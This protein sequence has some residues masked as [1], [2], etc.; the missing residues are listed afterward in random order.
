MYN[1]PEYRPVVG[2]FGG[3]A[4]GLSQGFNIANALAQ[5][6]RQDLL[7]RL[8][9]QQQEREA[10]KQ[11]ILMQILKQKAPLE[12][13]QLLAQISGSQAE[14]ALK[15]AQA[16]ALGAK[17]TGRVVIG[18]NG[19]PYVIPTDTSVSQGGGGQPNGTALASQQ[20]QIPPYSANPVSPENTSLSK[21]PSN[22]PPS[23]PGSQGSYIASPI[24]KSARGQASTWVNPFTHE[25]ISAV[26]PEGRTQLQKQRQAYKLLDEEIIP[27][28]IKYGSQGFAGPPLSP[29][30]NPIMHP[31]SF[32]GATIDQ[33]TN[34]GA[35][36]NYSALLN[37]GKEI[38]G[39]ARGTPKSNEGLMVNEGILA[40][41]PNETAKGYIARLMN[42]QKSE[43]QKHIKLIDDTL[44]VGG[45]KIP[46]PDKEEAQAPAATPS[47]FQV[48]KNKEEQIAWFQNQPPSIKQAYLNFLRK[49]EGK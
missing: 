2:P 17:D 32:A 41:H 49:N 10:Q 3:L 9:Q 28:L 13:Q 26:T 23:A 27:G 16:Q 46:A 19:L 22:A 42:L 48:F 14:A 25:T 44:R 39:T 12:R 24:G 4:Q 11:N 37:S 34:P 20:T 36:P 45:Y 40:R 35:A 47:S 33:I 18:P 43:I 38:L 15:R 29:S 30:M 31:V 21:V 8:Q 1:L 6:R 7:A 5:R